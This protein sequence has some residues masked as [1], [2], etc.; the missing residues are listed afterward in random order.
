MEKYMK[1]N[2]VS[3]SLGTRRSFCITLGLRKGYEANAVTYDADTVVQVAMDWMHRRAEAKQPFVTGTVTNGTVV[4]A[5]PEGSGNE[6]VAQF[7]GEV[8]PLYNG[9]LTNDEAKVLLNE[10]AAELGTALEQTRVY[11]AYCDETWIIQAE[12]SFTPTDET[13]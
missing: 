7:S 11:V 2:H 1:Y 12:A 8:N 6:P 5:W 13:L 10:L 4:Y 9:T 3:G